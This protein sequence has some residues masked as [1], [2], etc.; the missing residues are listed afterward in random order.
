[1]K[2]KDKLLLWVR[3]DVIARKVTFL[4]PHLWLR[5]SWIWRWT[6]HRHRIDPCV[7]DFE[8]VPSGS[9]TRQRWARLRGACCCSRRPRS[10][11]ARS[12]TRCCS[13]RCR[14]RVHATAAVQSNRWIASREMILI[15]CRAYQHVTGEIDITR[16]LLSFFLVS[17]SSIASQLTTLT[18]VSAPSSLFISCFICSIQSRGNR[19]MGN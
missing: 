1:M 17:F 3:E 5:P 2:R 12:C 14:S 7:F 16:I 11:A 6:R 15:E 18:A 9:R 4:L 13:S 8:Q 19:K 10:V